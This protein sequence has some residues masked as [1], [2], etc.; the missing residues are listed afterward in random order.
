MLNA[1][2]N[3]FPCPYVDVRNTSMIKC[4]Y[5]KAALEWSVRPSVPLKLE[6]MQKYAEYCQITFCDF[7][8]HLV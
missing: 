5:T 3:V 8:A 7:M 6:Y 1:R 2:V 4:L